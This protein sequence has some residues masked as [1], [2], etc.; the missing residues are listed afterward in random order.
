MYTAAQWRA[1]EQQ[2]GGAWDDDDGRSMASGYGRNRRDRCYNCGQRG[3]FKRE[4]SKLR[5]ESAA[6]QGLL[7]DVDVENV[8][9]L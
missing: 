2:Q 9:L 6:E 1:R 8:G 5:K 3:H 7:A 4:C